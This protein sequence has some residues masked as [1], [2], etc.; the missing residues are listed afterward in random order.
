MV[1]QSTKRGKGLPSETLSSHLA[2]RP[3]AD[4]YELDLC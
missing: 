3:A 1:S 4:K 2:G